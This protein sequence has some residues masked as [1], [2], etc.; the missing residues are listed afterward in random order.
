MQNKETYNVEVT[1]MDAMTYKTVIRTICKT[2]AMDMELDGFYL[3]GE[4]SQ[5]ENL[6]HW[7]LDRANEQHETVLSLISWKF[8]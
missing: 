7:I 5:R 6:G 3:R 1:M 4:D 8:V 2:N